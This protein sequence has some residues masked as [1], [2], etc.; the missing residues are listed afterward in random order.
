[1]K[2]FSR[3]ATLRAIPHLAH[4][5]CPEG[6]IYSFNTPQCSELSGLPSANRPLN[7]VSSPLK[8]KGLEYGI[9][10]NKGFAATAKL[11]EL[12]VWAGGASDGCM[13]G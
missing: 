11:A 12:A 3:K 5:V 7:S 10:R 4:G 8:P 1:M 13:M 2:E 6:L 9:V